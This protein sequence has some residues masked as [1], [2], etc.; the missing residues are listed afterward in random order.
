V[1]HPDTKATAIKT[2]HSLLNLFKA[3]GIIM[4]FLS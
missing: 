2:T 1:A 3:I 4:D